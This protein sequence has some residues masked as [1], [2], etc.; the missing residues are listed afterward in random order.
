MR[1][2]PSK[3]DVCYPFGYAYLLCLHPGLQTSPAMNNLLPRLQ[4]AG[5]HTE[6]RGYVMEI[7][8]S[9]LQ[10]AGSGLRRWHCTDSQVEPED[11]RR[12]ESDAGLGSGQN[13]KGA[14]VLANRQVFQVQ[15]SRQFPTWGPAREDA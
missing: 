2:K 15:H 4:T 14:K 12:N 7:M 13:G 5:S 3:R 9:K 10:M 1:K 11:N 6:G 8:P